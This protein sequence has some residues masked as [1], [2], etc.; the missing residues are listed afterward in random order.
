M[1]NVGQMML[2]SVMLVLNIPEN[3]ARQGVRPRIYG[4]IPGDYPLLLDRSSYRCF[5][6]GP[7]DRC[8]EICKLHLGIYG[9]C[10]ARECYCEGIDK[11]NLY[12]YAQYRDECSNL[13]NS[14]FDK[15]I[16]KN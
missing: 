2:L 1:K 16:A 5:E 10:S 7:N 6:N 4:W 13:I 9:Y 14:F 12:R 8:N 3:T 15:L 11:T